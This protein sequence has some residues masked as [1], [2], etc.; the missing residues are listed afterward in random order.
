MDASENALRN[1]G[2]LSALTVHSTAFLLKWRIDK[3]R[4]VD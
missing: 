4:L 2:F 1:A 3:S